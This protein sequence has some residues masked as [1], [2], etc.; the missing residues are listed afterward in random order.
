MGSKM[1]DIATRVAHDVGSAL[2]LRAGTETLVPA[3]NRPAGHET[4]DPLALSGADIGIDSNDRG[5]RV[6][7]PAGGTGIGLATA[8]MPR[9]IAVEYLTAAAP[10]PLAPALA[11]ADTVLSFHDSGFGPIAGPY[12]FEAASGDFSG[13]APVP[14]SWALGPEPHPP[15][16]Q[17]LTLGMG[18]AIDLGWSGGRGIVDLAGDDLFITNQ[19]TTEKAAVYA[20]ADGASFIRIGTADS[21]AGATQG[22]DIGAFGLSS[23]VAVRIVG[24]DFGGGAPGF[25]LVNVSA[26]VDIV[27]LPV[28]PDPLAVDDYFSG[29]RDQAISGNVLADN[30]AGA[31]I[32]AE[33]QPLTVTAGTFATAQG[34]SV[35]IAANGDFTYAP[36]TGFVG[37][38]SFDYTITDQEAGTDTGTAVLSLVTC[39]TTKFGSVAAEWWNGTACDDVIYG[40][41]GADTLL[42]YAGND[43]LMGDS[44]GDLIRG[45][46]GHDTII[47]RGAGDADKLYG[48]G[49]NDQ[50]FA[51]Q[52]STLNDFI[53]GGRGYDTVRN[54]LMANLILG[55]AVAS[56][57]GV[58]AIDLNDYAIQI[59]GAESLNLKSITLVNGSMIRGTAFSQTI[60]AS[61]GDD[62]IYGL[63]GNDLIRGRGDAD[64]I[65]GGAAAETIFGGAGADWITGG[66]PLDG[67]ELHGNGGAD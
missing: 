43:L 64:I 58:E 33:G 3:A 47:G 29:F 44:H 27:S 54:I 30:G 6:A 18:S 51:W 10:A 37:I 14:T 32:D 55:D 13:I 34:G 19:G 67:D 45:G 53:S 57:K 12:G 26:N 46:S 66:G 60:I 52:S 35:T 39:P 11:F 49:G 7:V 20:S 31:D 38:D 5:G 2:R 23:A 22:F 48:N 15:L 59:A 17:V 63:G 4:V 36:G 42:G 8:E 24:L 61:Q 41:G 1:E 28:P 21:A 16:N 62:T 40:G 9:T 56:W 50:F 25:D 65:F